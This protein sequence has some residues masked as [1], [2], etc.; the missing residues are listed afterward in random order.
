[1]RGTRTCLSRWRP[2]GKRRHPITIVRWMLDWD[3][4]TSGCVALLRWP[5]WRVPRNIRRI[6]YVDR[7][8][9]MGRTPAI[10]LILV[11]ARELWA[12]GGMCW[13]V[14]MRR[15]SPTIVARIRF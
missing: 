6:V 4:S 5:R 1:M 15:P 14:A 12:P 10:K 8:V 9:Q 7:R 11:L 2:W 13:L 3:V